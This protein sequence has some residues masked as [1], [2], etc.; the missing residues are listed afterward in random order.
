ME[1]NLGAEAVE[2]A[3]PYMGVEVVDGN[4]LYP[5]VADGVEAYLGKTDGA[6]S[7]LGVEVEEVEVLTHFVLKVSVNLKQ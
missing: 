1:Q 2:G 3:E 5:R 6:E 7:Y 4:K